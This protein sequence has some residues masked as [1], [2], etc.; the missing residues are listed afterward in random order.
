ME[1]FKKFT[2]YIILALMLIIEFYFAYNNQVP[3]YAKF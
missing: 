1:K 2:P 3:V